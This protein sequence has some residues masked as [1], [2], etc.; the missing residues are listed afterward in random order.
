MTFFSP[1]QEQA[2]NSALKLLKPTQAQLEHGLE[3]HRNLFVMDHF[4]FLP[5]DTWNHNMV[6]MK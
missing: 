3:L 2:W 6:I 5:H 1:N 4:G